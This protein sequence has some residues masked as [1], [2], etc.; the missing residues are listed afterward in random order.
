MALKTDRT[1]TPEIFI[2]QSIRISKQFQAVQS[3]YSKKIQK[4]NERYV[5]IYSKYKKGQ[6]IDLPADAKEGYDRFKIDAVV[7]KLKPRDKGSL[8]INFELQGF[9]VDSTGEK[10]NVKG[11]I[12]P[13]QKTY[14]DEPVKDEAEKI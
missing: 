5:K 6:I 4:L 9:F 11:V 14:E 12:I 13:Q 7:P 8:E 2:E 1:M 3:K 10:E